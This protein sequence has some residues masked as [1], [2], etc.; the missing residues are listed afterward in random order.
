M[1]NC[2][3]PWVRCTVRVFIYVLKCNKN[4]QTELTDVIVVLCYSYLMLFLLLYFHLFVPSDIFSLSL[5]SWSHFLF[6]FLA[7]IWTLSMTPALQGGRVVAYR[8]VAQNLTHPR[9]LPSVRETYSPLIELVCQHILFEQ[10]S[11]SLSHLAVIRYS[12][13]LTNS[14]YKN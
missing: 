10:L 12:I 2:L 11:L 8:V 4:K 6:V 1:H 5:F 9:V 7:Q 13:I 3:L 14:V